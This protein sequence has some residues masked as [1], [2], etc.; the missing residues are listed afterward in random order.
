MAFVPYENDLYLLDGETGKI[1][2]V[3]GTAGA[4][5]GQVQWLAETGLQGWEQVNQKYVTRYN[6]RAKMPAGSMIKCSLQYD[7]A[8]RWEEKLNMDNYLGSTKTL[9]MPVYPRRCDHIRM[10]L[11]GRGEIKVFSIARLMTSGGDG[12]RG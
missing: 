2:T 4:P 12:Q 3:T 11:E 1:L 7:S 9:L 10:R 5:E 6:I 8:G